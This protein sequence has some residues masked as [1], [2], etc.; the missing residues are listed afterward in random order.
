MR[1]ALGVGAVRGEVNAVG[2]AA[3]ASNDRRCEPIEKPGQ[4]LNCANDMIGVRLKIGPPC[5]AGEDG[6]GASSGTTRGIEIMRGITHHGDAGRR[7]PQMAGEGRH[8]AR[9]R[10]RA[11]AG[12]IAGDEIEM[13]VES[14]LAREVARGGLGI[15]GGDAK[16][17]PACG[18]SAKQRGQ[19][20]DRGHV[21]RQRRAD[22][23]LG[24]LQ[25]RARIPPPQRSGP[26]RPV[27]FPRSCDETGSCPQHAACKIEIKHRGQSL[28]RLRV[29]GSLRPH[30]LQQAWI[31][32]RAEMHQRAVLV[33]EDACEVFHAG[34]FM[35]GV[36]R[37]LQ[38]IAESTQCDGKAE[39]RQAMAK[40]PGKPKVAR[41]AARPGNLP[42]FIRQALG[43]ADLSAVLKAM[44]EKEAGLG[45]FEDGDDS[46]ALE[47][48]E[49]LL[50]GDVGGDE[51]DATLEDRLEAL[52][53]ELNDMNIAANGGDPQARAE[54][55]E[56]YH[57][58]DAAVAGGKVAPLRLLS[59]SRTLAAARMRV[60]ES[61]RDAVGAVFSKLPPEAIDAMARN[62]FAPLFADI[63]ESGGTAFDLH[64]SL[65][66]MLEA[67]PDPM[68]IALVRALVHAGDALGQHLRM[69]AAGFL[70]HPD[71]ALAAATAAALAASA[72]RAPV[73]SQLV[74][75]MIRM[76]AWLAEDRLAAVDASVQAMRRNSIAPVALEAFKP[77]KLVGTAF[78][79]SGAGSLLAV[80]KLGSRHSLATVL[81]KHGGVADA[82]LLRDMPKRQIDGHFAQLKGDM[83]AQEI[84]LPCFSRLLA[85]ALG[86]NRASG[87]GVPFRTLEVAEVLGLGP[88]Q[89]DAATAAQVLDELLAGRGDA[90]R[91]MDKHVAAEISRTW[92]EAGEDIENL[93]LPLKTRKQRIDRLLAHHLPGRRAFWALQCALSAMALKDQAKASDDRWLP[94]ALAGRDIAAGVALEKIP[95]MQKIAAQTVDYFRTA[96]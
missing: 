91:Q 50:A 69:A 22:H 48:M 47:L 40:K 29:A 27:L 87:A 76:R 14:G 3:A 16:P 34:L 57:L 24:F 32:R 52:E 89:P 23:E 38:R 54:C 67:F 7:D 20:A 77:V 78:D 4:F 19:V 12:I 81:L 49:G 86:R 73:E 66:Q 9:R 45:L 41:K 42:A 61:V 60:P 36:V 51:S 2:P 95:L 44:F 10:F 68:R 70:L 92:F 43:D 71:A 46:S 72:V 13:G 15:I 58:L 1:L 59:I 21:A 31:P 63:A 56:I 93:L 17:E 39:R 5:R 11:M 64:E 74:E 62:A 82:M 53:M 25:Q 18:Q 79:G 90:P 84:G 35:P 6:N 94:L 8:H 28:Q 80:V 65:S 33:E 96:S 55:G 88:V 26:Q 30:H 85:L 83:V 37:R 75:R